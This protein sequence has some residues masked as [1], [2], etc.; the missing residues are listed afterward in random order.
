MNT[1]DEKRKKE[2]TVN[3]MLR[4][5]RLR[6]LRRQR[7]K[8]NTQG[9]TSRFGSGNSMCKEEHLESLDC[10]SN[11]GKGSPIC[12]RSFEV[13]KECLATQRRLR[14]AANALGK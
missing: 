13:Y 1:N 8:S 14:L 10:I 5:K 3:R 4:E 12:E 2:E 11:Y 9:K 6:D 7:R